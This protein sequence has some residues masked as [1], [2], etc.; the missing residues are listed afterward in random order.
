M[1]SLL[2]AVFWK[3]TSPRFPSL[4]EVKD[5]VALPRLPSRQAV[6]TCAADVL[7]RLLWK[8]STLEMYKLNLCSH[9]YI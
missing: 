9:H 3:G 2:V 5:A 4:Q 1:P 7:P 8:Y 6:D